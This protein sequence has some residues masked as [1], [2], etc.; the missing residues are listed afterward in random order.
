LLFS[1][2]SEKFDASVDT[3]TYGISLSFKLLDWMII[4]H[5]K[6]LSQPNWR[7]NSRYGLSMPFEAWFKY[8]LKTSSSNTFYVKHA[9]VGSQYGIEGTPGGLETLLKLHGLRNTVY[10]WKGTMFPI[11]PILVCE[12]V[13]VW[14]P[15]SDHIV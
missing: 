2:P 4:G 9:H 3:G 13:W 11:S 6:D 5:P 1:D 14:N 15:L 7:S 10:D 8:A 12:I